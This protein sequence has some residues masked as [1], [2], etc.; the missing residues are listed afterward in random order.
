MTLAPDDTKDTAVMFFQRIYRLDLWLIY[1]SANILNTLFLI[2][3][4]WGI[5]NS[6]YY[7]DLDKENANPYAIGALWILAVISAYGAIF[8]LWTPC[9]QSTV[10]VD[11]YVSIL[12]LIGA[13]INFLWAFLFF[14]YEDLAGAV[15]AAVILFAYQFAITA[16]IWS[17]DF[18]AMLLTIPLVIMNGYIL[19]TLIHVATLN[20]III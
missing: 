13:F 10:P 18:K 12:Y 5:F 9:D 19:Y 20:G 2:V 4:I 16:Y 6:Q 3:V 1:L 15:V 14:Y 11:V 17:L 7:I 8:M